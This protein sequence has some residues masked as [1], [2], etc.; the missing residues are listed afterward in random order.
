MNPRIAELQPGASSPV[1]RAGLIRFVISTALAAIIFSSYRLPWTPL[2]VGDVL[3]MVSSLAACMLTRRRL[4][5]LPRYLIWSFVFLNVA[6]FGGFTYLLFPAPWFSASRFLASLV[7]VAVMALLSAPIAIALS[8]YPDRRTIYRSINAVVIV[9]GV[10][11]LLLYFAVQ[12]GAVSTIGVSV[13]FE[14]AVTRA[15]GLMD[16]PANY[17]AFQAFGFAWIL[18]APSDI[19]RN[20]IAARAIVSASI[21]ASLSLVAI[22]IAAVTVVATSMRR[23]GALNSRLTHSRPRRIAMIVV[24][25]GMILVAPGF[26]PSVRQATVGRAAKALR[27]NDASATVRVA[28]SWKPTAVMFERAP[29]TGSS[30]GNLGAG[31]LAVSP[32]LINEGLRED[33]FSWNA[34]AFVAGSTGLAGL[35]AWIAIVLSLYRTRKGGALIVVAWMFGTSV[36]QLPTLWVAFAF[37]AAAWPSFKPRASV[38]PSLAPSPSA[39]RSMATTRQ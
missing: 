38:N 11:A 24:V 34:V 27:G 3:L 25:V 37:V 6:A 20:R 12:I 13:A 21:V 23:G 9:H 16:E 29:L 10:A 31:A 32:E 4:T 19:R 15:R 14:G 35:T 28:G 26:G 17:G 8:G 22:S 7:R 30:L 36:I 18:L 39:S 2:Y 5:R 33:R 1:Q